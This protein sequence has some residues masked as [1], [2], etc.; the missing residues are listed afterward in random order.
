[1]RLDKLLWYLRLAKTRAAAQQRVASG[2]IRLNGRRVERSAQ[3]VAVGDV[4]T[5]PHGTQVQVIEVLALPLRRGPAPEAQGCYRVLDQTG[6][7]AIAAADA[8]QPRGDPQ[9]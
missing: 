8:A 2:H 5:L 6:A 7:S 4:L 9:P 1:M 3:A